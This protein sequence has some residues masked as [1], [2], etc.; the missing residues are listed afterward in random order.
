MKN[1][2]VEVQLDPV[3]CHLNGQGGDGRS[4]LGYYFAK[5]NLFFTSSRLVAE[6]TARL[7]ASVDDIPDA[8]FERYVGIMRR[9]P[10]AFRIV[11]Q[12]LC[13]PDAV[14]AMKDATAFLK[15][16]FVRFPDRTYSED[17]KNWNRGCDHRR[18]S[19]RAPWAEASADAGEGSLILGPW[20]LA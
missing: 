6:A 3:H 4:L 18:G 9:E 20:R 16:F 17:R 8:D 19:S 10:F 7:H 15:E 1:V 5:Q 12:L 11:T 2:A 14:I 13:E